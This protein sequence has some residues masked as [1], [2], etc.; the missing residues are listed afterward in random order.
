MNM[1][2]LLA[3]NSRK[4]PN[5]EAIVCQDTRLTYRELNSLVNKFAS[6]IRKKEIHAEDRVALFLPNVPEFAIAYLAVQRIGA[7]VVPIN[8]KLSPEELQHILSDSGA[9][10]LIAHELLFDTVKQLDSPVSKIKTG[11]ATG[12]WMSFWTMLEKERG[13]PIECYLRED[14]LSTILYTSGTTGKPKGV[15]FSYRSILEVATMIN[16]EMEVKPE[17]RILL[18]MPLSHSAPLHLFFVAGLMTGSTL[19]LTPTFT[20][21][22]FL[23]TIEKERTTH[24]FGAPVAYLTTMQMADP[25]ARDLSSMKWWVYGGAP[26]S[27]KEVHAMKQAFPSGRFVC[28]YGLTEA[29]P[30]GTLLFDE[31]HTEKAGSIG[32]RAAWGT[33]IRLIDDVGEIVPQG[34]VGEIALRGEGNMR[35]YFRK[36]HETEAV[37]AGEWL[38]TG[39]LAMQ[40]EDGY[41]WVVDRKKDM[42]ISGGVNIYPKEIENV[43]LEIEGIREVAVIGVPHPEWGETVKAVYAG[44]VDD[45]EIRSTLEKRL[46]SYKVPR[47][48]EQVEELPRNASGKILKQSLKGAHA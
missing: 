11:E 28:V 24:F 16:I 41:Y 27:A 38:R 48:Y 8:V 39:D 46:A 17:S 10:A 6:A 12:E 1:S 25:S 15:L 40:D 42:I 13:T 33:E 36:S 26:L 2:A 4:Y 21:D 14:D 9:R 22:L 18:S 30:S 45:T 44:D 7:I 5:Q 35:E 32:R 43:M 3:R 37:Y 20:P 29:G 31:E 23:D 19:V 47:I 34:D